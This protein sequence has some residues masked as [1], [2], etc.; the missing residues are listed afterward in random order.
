HRLRNAFNEY[1]WVLC[2]GMA[3]RNQ[4]KEVYRF[5]GSMTDVTDQKEIEQ[6]LF[7]DAFHDQLTGLPNR[8]LFMEKL[9]RLLDHPKQN[10]EWLFAVL[11][12]DVDKFKMINDSLGHH[13]GD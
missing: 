12:L 4:N 11:F 6:Q 13:I 7:H 3:A 2:R 10:E 1:R 5:A 9:Q 8:T